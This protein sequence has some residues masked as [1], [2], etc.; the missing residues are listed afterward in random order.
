MKFEFKFDPAVLG[1]LGTADSTKHFAAITRG[2]ERESLRITESGTIAQTDH[3]QALGSALTHPTITTDFSESL[4]ELVTPPTHCLNELQQSLH[5]LHQF[6]YQ[7]LDHELLW[8]ASMPV[9]IFGAAEIRLAH[10]GSSNI[11]KM[12]QVY[13]RG[14]CYRYGKVMQIISGIHYNFS[15][16]REWFVN[17]HTQLGKQE[18]L[19]EFI[20]A[21]YFNLMRNYLEHYWLLM[22]LFGA[23][24]VCAASSVVSQVPDYLQKLD[25]QS[26]YAPYATS[27][28]MSGLGYSNSSQACICVSRENIDQYVKDLL[29]LTQ[30]PYPAYQ[31]LGLKDEQGEYK[32]LNTNLLQIENEYYSAIRPKQVTQPGERPALALKARGVEYIE[33]RCMDVN[34][35]VAE[36]IDANQAAFVDV[37]LM[38]CLL[39]N[40]S[41]NNLSECKTKTNNIPKVVTEGRRPGL[42][43]DYRGQAISLRDWAESIFASCLE[44]AAIMDK[45]LS[46][47]MFVDAVNAQCAKLKD[48]SLTPSA[49]VLDAMQSSGLSYEELMLKQAKQY[50]DYFSSQPIGPGLN[51]KFI[52]LA[53][54][55][56]LDQEHIEKNDSLSF[57]AFLQAYFSQG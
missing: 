26:Y 49:K 14:L 17:L 21:S 6:V 57:E 50:R 33:V 20:D 38:F 3:P 53:K 23:S 18:S 43:L 45:G 10:Y 4:I 30:E 13:R 24:P 40:S 27:L 46:K 1:W 15:L 32:Q 56:W 52:E 51:Q 44:L 37:F 42:M 25:E 31:E 2:V 47:P 5:N 22:Y 55:S 48:S 39:L 41:P 16:P 29:A 7:N 12:K 8:P 54:Q 34:P 36:G 11:A 35:F 28:R 19:R 9:S